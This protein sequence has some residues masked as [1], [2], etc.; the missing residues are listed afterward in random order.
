M[1]VKEK[2]R[3]EGDSAPTPQTREGES[4]PI[5]PPREDAPPSPQPSFSPLPSQIPTL[6]IPS[7]IHASSPLSLCISPGPM[8]A[9]SL[10]PSPLSD[11]GM[12]DFEENSMSS[13]T[14]HR[15]KHSKAQQVQ[16]GS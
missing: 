11:T 5:P 2:D 9:H 15:G 7:P 14:E 12:R 3:H 13:D 6:T 8:Q 10:P 1:S 4:A 16:V